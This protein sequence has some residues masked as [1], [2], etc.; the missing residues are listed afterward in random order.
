MRDHVYGPY[1]R[2][3]LGGFE[4]IDFLL[5]YFRF[6]LGGDCAGSLVGVAESDHVD[7]GFKSING[8]GRGVA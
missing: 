8:I 3:W 5:L 7:F 2:C 4:Q 1:V 6:F